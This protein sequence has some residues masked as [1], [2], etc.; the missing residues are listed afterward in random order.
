MFGVNDGETQQV[1]TF[2][3]KWLISDLWKENVQN[4]H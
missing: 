3:E 4:T 1:N 2:L